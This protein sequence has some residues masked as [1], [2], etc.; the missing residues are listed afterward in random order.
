MFIENRTKMCCDVK[1]KLVIMD[2]NLPQNEG[3]EAIEKMFEHQREIKLGRKRETK[4][5]MF[6]NYLLSIQ[7]SQMGSDRSNLIDSKTRKKEKAFRQI[8][9]ENA[10]SINSCTDND[11]EDGD[12]SFS[13]NSQMNDFAIMPAHGKHKQVRE[14]LN[15]NYDHAVIVGLTGFID[16]KIMEKCF[17][18]GLS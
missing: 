6:N 10:S 17:N 2:L 13:I 1:Y 11:D 8:T 12:S 5:K 16:D 9:V 7:G 3:F 15:A 18:L 4:K 14:F